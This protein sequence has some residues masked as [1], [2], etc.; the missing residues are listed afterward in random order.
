LDKMAIKP[1]LGKGFADLIPDDVVIEKFDVTA[2]IDGQVSELHEID[3][4]KIINDEEQ[5]RKE[6][7]KE[8]LNELADSIREYGVLQPITVI[9]KGDKFQIVSGE[10]RW[11]ASKIAG[12]KTVPAIVRTLNGQQ[13]LEQAIIEN[14]QREDLKPMEISTALLKMRTQS[15]MSPEEI[16]KKIGKSK[17][18]IS[19]F[20]RLMKLPDF[21]KDAVAAGKLSEG[22]ARQVLALEGHLDVQKVLVDNIIKKDWSV[23]KAEQF[24]SAFKRSGKTDIKKATKAVT[25][26]NDFTRQLTKKIGLPVRQKISGRGSGQIIISYK[27]ESE[28]KKLEKLL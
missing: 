19:N 9:A 6:F 3:I 27:S 14:L 21:A 26:K 2:N 25:Q 4:D 8:L 16:S 1:G 18:V 23:R 24:V 15:N 7:N 11:R 10:R 28:L 5:P 22:H 17:A 12:R 20:L 13:K